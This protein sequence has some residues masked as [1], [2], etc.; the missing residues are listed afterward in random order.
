MALQP[1]DGKL[2]QPIR[3]TVALHVVTAATQAH[4]ALII[5]HV[6]LLH[7]P[8]GGHGRDT[9]SHALALFGHTA[10]GSRSEVCHLPREQKKQQA[11]QA[12]TR[13]PTKKGTAVT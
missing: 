5:C 10:A 7:A 11:R 1:A 13:S 4:L 6:T 3:A 2:L 9:V 8:A 12:D